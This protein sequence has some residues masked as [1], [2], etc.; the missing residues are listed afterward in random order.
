MKTRVE[1][2]ITGR[3]QGV[4]YRD[5]AQKQAWLLG[6]VGI[7][8]NRP[9][10]SVFVVAEGEEDDLKKFVKILEQGPHA[11]HVEKLETLYSA[12]TGE[13]PGFEIVG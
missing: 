8:E 2:K 10:G 3:V 6:V 4:A 11:S 5:F 13:Y 7:A 1:C 12:A 9:D